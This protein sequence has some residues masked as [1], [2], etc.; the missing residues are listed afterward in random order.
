M[1]TRAPLLANCLAP[2]WVLLLT[3]CGSSAS[4]SGGHTLLPRV[5]Y[6]GGPLVTAPAVVT[7]TFPGDPNAAQLESLG[8]S[9]A[10]SSWWDTVRS[11]YCAAAGAGCVGDG[12]AGTSVEVTTPPATMY[13]DSDQGGASTLQGWLSNAITTGV[14][15]EPDSGPTSN[16]IYVLYLPSTT[17]I[18][19]DGES[20]CGAGSFDGYHN[21]M[22]LG[23]MQ[24]PYVVAIEC[25]ALSPASPAA[26]APTLLENTTITASH[27]IVEAATDPVP[28]TG[29]ALDETNTDT[30]G[31]ID[32]T[33]GGE[34]ADMCVDL[35]D[36]NQDQTTDGTFTVQRIWSNAQAAAGVD[37]CN[38]R[39]AGD[40][41]FNA[42]PTQQFFV[43]GVG[44]SVTFEVDAFSTASM[45]DWT[46]TAQDWSD[47]TTSYLSFAIAGSVS[48]D[49]GPQIQVNNGSQVEVTMTLLRE[50]GALGTGEADGSFI[51]FSGSAASPLA[52]HFWPIAVM[53]PA[54]AANAGVSATPVLGHMHRNRRRRLVHSR[55]R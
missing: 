25:E 10:T 32:V 34:A 14:L 50:P 9:V 43:V 41:Y 27:E 44:Q 29:Y 35:L 16:T 26:M 33:G 54:D 19:L 21:A 12:P 5:V 18:V 8:Q 49:L 4:K 30:W 15:P 20:S 11:G 39:R 46:L 3:A 47:S 23:S 2:A 13:T 45:S 42:A 31:W 6:Q 48:G 53:S 36:L 38:P 7:V 55:L 37:P 51:S 17:T 22:A 40:V 24:V 52:G 1:V 28:P